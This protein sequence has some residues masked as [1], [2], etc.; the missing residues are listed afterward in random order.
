MWL[1]IWE[2]FPGEI[3]TEIMLKRALVLSMIVH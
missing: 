2:I 1:A 3:D